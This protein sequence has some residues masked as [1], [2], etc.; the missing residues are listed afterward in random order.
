MLGYLSKIA[1]RELF[2]DL[3]TG[4]GWTTKNGSILGG[5]IDMSMHNCIFPSRVDFLAYSVD[6]FTKFLNI[7]S[8]PFPVNNQFCIRSYLYT[9]HT[10]W[11]L[12]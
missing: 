11:N 3:A 10:F 8:P 6:L 1:T 7:Y 12:T 4:G 5:K 9:N 2:V